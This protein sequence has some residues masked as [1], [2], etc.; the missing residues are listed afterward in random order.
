MVQVLLRTALDESRVDQLARPL[1]VAS[2]QWRY[3]INYRV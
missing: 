2:E 3:V 1:A